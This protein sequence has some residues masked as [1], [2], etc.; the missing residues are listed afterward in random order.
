MRFR[1][2]ALLVLIVVAACNGNPSNA[3]DVASTPSDNAP[4]VV[5]TLAQ[6][7][8]TAG[9]FLNDWTANN[10][11]AMYK[12]LHIKSQGVITEPDF[13]ASYS[14]TAQTLTLLPNG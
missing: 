5:L 3:S 9:D 1:R 13:V 7:Q 8:Q 2:L 10:Y 12:L 6:A 4:T 11:D 14:D